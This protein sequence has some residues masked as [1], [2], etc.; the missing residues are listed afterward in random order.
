MVAKS[1]ATLYAVDTATRDSRYFTLA[2]VSQCVQQQ[3]S[4]L[5]VG[6]NSESKN[7]LLEREI[8]M[9]ENGCTHKDGKPGKHCPDCGEKVPVTVDTIVD[10]VLGRLEER[11]KARKPKENDKG[12]RTLLDHVLED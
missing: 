5:V 11:S 12:E 4:A 9:P 10:L 6:E 2:S 7:K 8:T 1:R 3:G